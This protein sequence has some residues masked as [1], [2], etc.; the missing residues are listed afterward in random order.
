[1]PFVHLLTLCGKSGLEILEKERSMDGDKG[2]DG[3][4][5][6]VNYIRK[7]AQLTVGGLIRQS[8]AVQPKGEVYLDNDP[9]TTQ[10]EI[11]EIEK[12]ILAKNEIIKRN[13]ISV[14]SVM[15]SIPK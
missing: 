15:S 2:F 1:M 11:N 8:L 6:A 12:R 4:E 3:A 5:V 13:V 9:L 7:P 10:D 14:I